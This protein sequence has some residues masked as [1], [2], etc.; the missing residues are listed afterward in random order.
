MCGLGGVLDVPRPPLGVV[1]IQEIGAVLPGHGDVVFEPIGPAHGVL[2]PL[3]SK[4]RPHR[5]GDAPG[6]GHDPRPGVVEQNLSG[7]RQAPVA[8]GR[9]AQGSAAH[10]F[11]IGWDG[12][13]H[14]VDVVLLEEDGIP[15]KGDTCREAAGAAG[16]YGIA[17][18]R[19]SLVHI[20]VEDVPQL[21]GVNGGLVAAPQA[22]LV[23]A[24]EQQV[25]H[26]PG[27]RKL[28]G[29]GVGRHTVLAIQGEDVFVEV[30]LVPVDL[31]DHRGFVVLCVLRA[32]RDGHGVPSL[33]V[34]LPV[35]A[36]RLDAVGLRVLFI[37]FPVGE[38][39]G[40]TGPGGL[41][42]AELV[43]RRVV[44]CL[45]R[46]DHDVG[47]QGGE[48]LPAGCH[49]PL[50]HTIIV[51]RGPVHPAQLV[52]AEQTAGVLQRLVQHPPRP[53]RQQGRVV[54]AQVSHIPQ[55]PVLGAQVVVQAG[56]LVLF[57]G[58]DPVGIGYLRQSHFLSPPRKSM[59]RDR[60]SS[61]FT[62]IVSG[63]GARSFVKRISAGVSASCRCCSSYSP[64]SP[65][66]RKVNRPWA[67]RMFPSSSLAA[68]FS[69]SFR[70]SAAKVSASAAV[71]CLTF[72][73]ARA[74]E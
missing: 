66:A 60:T 33:E 54:A 53:G 31:P 52:P 67:T 35:D 15:Q 34:V 49:S 1:D 3:H 37:Q 65:G 2:E 12:A 51:E 9:H 10:H 32:S 13:V 72:I 36:L 71:A 29:F 18:R 68:N 73:R 28:P 57:G 43:R 56:E 38:G 39:E 17:V 5:L 27:D 4:R 59:N 63:A 44:V 11:K 64:R 70:S 21:G 19:Q 24:D 23:L 26:C 8:A 6:V 25:R 69:T 48:G 22:V 41:Q 50:G 16:V 58:L 46:E 30:Q 47:S 14:L 74:R 62:E 55:L 20:P 61:D 42:I 7:N 40:G 45:V